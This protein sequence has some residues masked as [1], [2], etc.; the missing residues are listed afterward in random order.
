MNQNNHK[1]KAPIIGADGNIF[2]LI[3]IAFKALRKE[4][5]RQEAKEMTQRIY[6]SQSYDEALSILSEYIDPVSADQE[7][8]DYDHCDDMDFQ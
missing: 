1:P 5:L 3:G 6:A 4:G 2:N 8:D 7:Y